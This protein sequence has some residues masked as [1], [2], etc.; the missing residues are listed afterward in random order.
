MRTHGIQASELGDG[1]VHVWTAR[2]DAIEDPEL[3]AAY[4]RLMTD[5]ERARQRRYLLARSRHEHLVTRAL[6]RTT[7]SRY[8]GRDPTAWRFVENRYGRPE[9]APGSEC[10]LRFNVSHTDGL[11]ACAVTRGREVGVDVEALDRRGQTVEVAERFFAPREVAALRALPAAEQRERFFTYWTLKEA[12]IKARGMGL[13]IPLARFWFDVGAPERIGIAFD[14]RL[15]DDPAEW[16][17]ELHRPSA[18]HRLAVGVRRGRAP[19]L[20]IAVRET[21]PLA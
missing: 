14:P 3:L 15:E 12:Y 11:I 18:R 7:L 10:G 19:D 21:T 6:L 8:A 2:P 13:A 1:D 5:A 4:E 17:F 16:Q 9:L 20:R